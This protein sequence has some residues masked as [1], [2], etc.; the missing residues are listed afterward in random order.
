MYDMNIWHQQIGNA[1]VVKHV[2]FLK[3]RVVFVH[4]YIANSNKCCGTLCF[5]DPSIVTSS[6][7]AICEMPL[8][9]VFAPNTVGLNTA[10][11][12]VITSVLI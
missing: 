9:S 12:L 6:R 1:L 3:A 7:E 11:L 5:K 2:S 8:S 4:H 10:V